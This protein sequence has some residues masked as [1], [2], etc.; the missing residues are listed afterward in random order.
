MK[1]NITISVVIPTFN[2][3]K[4]I[5]RWNDVKAGKTVSF[6]SLEKIGGMA[7]RGFISGPTMKTL[8]KQLR[9]NDEKRV[10]LDNG[11]TKPLILE[12]W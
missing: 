10:H 7:R 5:E 8:K 9:A 11:E 12:H 3:E 6:Q 4:T 1:N 2:R